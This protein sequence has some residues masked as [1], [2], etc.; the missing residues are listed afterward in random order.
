MHGIA[1]I[2][3]GVFVVALAR[4]LVAPRSRAARSLFLGAGLAAAA[5][6]LIQVGLEITLNRHVAGHGGADTTTA[7]FYAANIADTVKLILR[8]IAIASA[9]RCAAEA[10]AVARWLR[11]LGYVLLPIL[12]VGGLAFVVDSAALSAVLD[13]SLV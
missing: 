1:G 7:L 5:V 2:A 11:W 12:V 3:F 6:S 4:L 10:E 9:T 13:L 8:G